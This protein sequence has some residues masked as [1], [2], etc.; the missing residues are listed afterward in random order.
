MYLVFFNYQYK[1][2]H[3]NIGFM[4]RADSPEFGIFLYKKY[5][6]TSLVQNSE[7]TVAVLAAKLPSEFNVHAQKAP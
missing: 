3:G 6:P 1:I 2:S 5:R 7:Y 4:E